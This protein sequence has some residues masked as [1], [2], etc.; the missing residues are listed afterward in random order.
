MLRH[1]GIP[2]A[3]P[4]A[5]RGHGLPFERRSD[6]QKPVSGSRGFAGALLAILM[7]A[8][9]AVLAQA[10]AQT[11]P[12]K[13]VR[14]VVPF[15]PGGGTD[16]MARALA[17]RLTER[18][19]QQVVIDN[20]P[21]AGATIGVEIA[22]RAPAD[23]YT[24]LL[25]TITNAVGMSLYSKLAWDLRRDFAPVGLMAT[26][27]HIVV[28]HPSVPAKSIKELVALAKARPGDL[29]Y[30][31]AGSGTVTHLAGELF[32]HMTGAKMTHV[33]Y[34]GGGPS[35]VALLSG[36]VGVAF[37][38]MPS[39]IGHVRSGRV[40]GIAV[41]TRQRSAAVP[42][43]PTVGE[44]GVPGF[45]V[46]SWYGISAPAGTP[47]EII[48]RL[49]GDVARV[50]ALPDVKERLARSGFEVLLSSPEEFGEFV[51]SEI[52]KWAKVVKASGVRID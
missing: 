38:T 39:V 11:Y 51:R 37:S 10:W 52:D 24:L 33:P 21:G 15:P 16:T 35:V 8:V 40:R 23:G 48:A 34:K 49:S 31:S 3:N 13:P 27:P 28:V 30:S 47:R 2:L 6:V 18:L 41:T 36:E 29:L 20:R 1:E 45:E 43:L 22:S 4:R 50:L 26:T 46:G 9:P 17:P 5:G 44:A 25:A 7:T 14:L 42:D 32:A 19:G 12:T